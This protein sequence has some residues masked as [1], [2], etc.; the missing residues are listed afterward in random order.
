MFIPPVPIPVTSPHQNGSKPLESHEP[1]LDNTDAK[2]KSL[3]TIEDIRIR[4]HNI[5]Q[6]FTFPSK[7]EFDPKTTGEKPKLTYA[8]SNA[9]IHGYEDALVRLQQE[10]DAVESYGDD[11]VIKGRKELVKSIEAAQWTG[12]IVIFPLTFV[13]SAFVPTDTMPYA[14]RVF[15]DNQPL[16]HVIEAIRSWLVGAPVGDSGWLAFA[17]CIGIIAVSVP[18]ATWL[19]KRQTLR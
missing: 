15:A 18:L 1:E 11:D 19:F 13:S 8:K 10:L 5:L 16:T 4:F 12:F 14:L 17:W 9:P 6:A 3:S 2:A 7:L